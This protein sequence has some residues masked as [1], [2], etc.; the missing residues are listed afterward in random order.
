M[1]RK[2]DSLQVKEALTTRDISDIRADISKLAETV[3]KGFSG[4]H[5]RQDMTNGKVLKAGTDILENKVLAEK[6]IESLKA[7]FKYNRIIWYMLT[8]SVSVIIMLGSYIILK[9][10]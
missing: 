2:G 3:E 5:Q 9:H 8:V 10:N 6:Q 1:P 4:V 7:E